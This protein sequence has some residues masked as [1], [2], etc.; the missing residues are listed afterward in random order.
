MT[1]AD[2]QPLTAAA[3]VMLFLATAIAAFTGLQALARPSHFGDRLASAR[4][5]EAS[6]G[7][8]RAPGAGGQRF[9]EGAVCRQATVSG[10]Q[11]LQR[12]LAGMAAGRQLTVAELQVAPGS[13]EQALA[14]LASVEVQLTVRGAQADALAFTADLERASPLVFIDRLELRPKSGAHELKILGR[15]YC[16]ISVRR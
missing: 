6:L 12:Q 9:P 10:S 5:I 16:S 11:A 7:P 4:A 3:A 1:R 2:I 13:P 15:A 8:A 14:R